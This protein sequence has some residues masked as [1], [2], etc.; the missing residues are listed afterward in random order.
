[1]ANKAP[2]KPFLPG[3]PRINRKGRPLRSAGYK[4]WFASIFADML[5]RPA[6]AKDPR[7]FVEVAVEKWMADVTSDRTLSTRQSFIQMLFDSGMIEKLDD[8]MQ[9]QKTTDINYLRYLIHLHLFDEQREV[10]LSKK[11]QKMLICGRRAGKTEALVA[12]IADAAIS[13]DKGTILY[14]SITAQRAYEI[15][16]QRLIELLDTL[17]VSYKAKTVPQASIEFA[18]GVHLYLRGASSKDELEKARGEGYLL[19]VLDEVQSIKDD[20][21]KYLINDILMP[22]LMEYKGLLVLAGTPPRIAGSYIE[23]EWMNEKRDASRFKWNITT[24]PYI[25]DSEHALEMIRK[26]RGLSENDPVYRREYLGEMGVYDLDALVYRLEKPKNYYDDKSL[27]D[28]IQSQPRTDLWL[29]G[30]IDFGFSDCD[31]F[32]IFLY[33]AK[34]KEKF[35]LYEYKKNRELLSEFAAEIRKGIDYVYAM[36]QLEQLVNRDYRI[37]GDSADPRSLTDLRVSYKLPV[38]PVKSKS[39]KEMSVERL[40]DEV[41]SGNLKIREGSVFEDEGRQIIFKR[42]ANDQL[43]REVD[44]D[45]YHPDMSDAILYSLRHYWDTSL[46]VVKKE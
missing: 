33:S 22:G 16:W 11:K 18:S 12:M 42:D 34:K 46:G 29:T 39:N 14:I 17:H 21:I 3:D 41:R 25:E 31:A 20:N 38:V 27:W 19:A 4:H 36:P 5:E 13:H 40:Q 24:N 7:P 1:M 10:L 45:Y 44:G 28:W 6:S 9:H 32:C 8:I 23:R 35:L 26:E 15:I 37:Y 43:L 2:A 30:G